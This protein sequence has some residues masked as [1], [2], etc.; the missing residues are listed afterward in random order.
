M[1]RGMIDWY[2]LVSGSV[3]TGQPPLDNLEECLSAESL[4]QR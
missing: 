2:E 3:G 1:S 4:K